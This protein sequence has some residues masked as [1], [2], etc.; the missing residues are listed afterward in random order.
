MTCGFSVLKARH[1]PLPTNPFFGFFISFFLANT[2]NGLLFSCA[3][4][5]TILYL[6]LSVSDVSTEQQLSQSSCRA[7]SRSRPFAFHLQTGRNL[8]GSLTEQCCELASVCTLAHHQRDNGRACR[9]ACDWDG[10]EISTGAMAPT[11]SALAERCPGARLLL[12]KRCKTMNQA[13]ICHRSH[14]NRC[15]LDCK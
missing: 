10:A 13:C 8:P 2:V 1:T 7:S 6:S 14:S 5:S 4:C 15:L 12:L 11:R 9:K 3:V